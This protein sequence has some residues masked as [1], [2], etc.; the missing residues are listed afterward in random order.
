MST[1]AVSLNDVTD[2]LSG[3]AV[4]LRSMA[5]EPGGAWTPGWYKAE[6]V[7]GFST[8][9]SGKVYTTEDAVS[10]KGDSRNLRICVRVARPDGQERTM[11]ETFNYRPS[12]F[13]SERITFVKEAR[14]EFKD[15]RSWP[16]KDAQRSSLAIA[17]IGQFQ[18][19]I[20]VGSLKP[21]EFVGKRLDVRLSTDD[22]G[23]N[24]LTG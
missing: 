16:D 12:D 10:S 14:V 13:T 17:K 24:I 22:N 5:E 7:E 18:K 15:I 23:F 9:K 6:V 4:D 20:D 11:Q 8:A 21:F 2:G 19:A 3:E 1:S